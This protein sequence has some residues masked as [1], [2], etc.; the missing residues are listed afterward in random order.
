M[1]E[2]IKNNEQGIL[3]IEVREILILLYKL[4]R[5]KFKEVIHFYQH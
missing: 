2:K 5:I 3:N 4:I 1:K